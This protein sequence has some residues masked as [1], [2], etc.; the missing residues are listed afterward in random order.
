MILDPLK[1]IRG[2]SAGAL[3]IV[4]GV[5]MY[6]LASVLYY[7]SFATGLVPALLAVA[8][9]YGLIKI[10]Q[11]DRAD[12]VSYSTPRLLMLLIVLLPALSLLGQ[13]ALNLSAMDIDGRSSIGH[14]QNF[15][16]VGTLWL[17]AGAAIATGTVARSNLFA[18]G[19]VGALLFL[20]WIGSDGL[21][22]VNY[23]RLSAGLGGARFSHLNTSDYA[24]FSLALAYGL[25]S[26]W[27]RIIVLVAAVF[28]L[29]AL[30]GRSALF[31]FTAAT[32]LHW[33]F[34]G[35]SRP[36]SRLIGGFL[37]VSVLGVVFIYL[38]D[39]GGAEVAGKDVLFSQGYASDSSVVARVDQIMLGVADLGRQAMFGDPSLIVKRFA[40]AGAYM[41]N[42]LSA[43]Q[44]YGFAFF[45]VLVAS[46]LYC[47]RYSYVNRESYDDSLSTAFVLLLIYASIS[48]VIAKA[49]TFYLLWLVL[50]FWLESA[51]LARAREVCSPY[52]GAAGR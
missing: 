14:A 3:L 39:L 7:R 13:S 29:F 41:H 9:L 30:G 35:G 48:V 24:V 32:V 44:F 19:L 36:A 8:V 10:I 23:G 11:A 4:V 21:F 26:G 43:W 52:G 12:G 27:L 45:V 17:I 42:L 40:S 16:M 37:L 18:I 51:V 25:A 49:I 2:S 38:A 1:L 6:G 5:S 28:V 31:A 33:I 34:W 22:V 15:W 46:L 50:G 20:L 47:L